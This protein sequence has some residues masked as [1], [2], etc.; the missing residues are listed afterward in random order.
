MSVALSASSVVFRVGGDSPAKVRLGSVSIQ[1]VPTKPSLIN[2]TTIT[3]FPNATFLRITPHSDGGSPI[4]RYKATFGA[5]ELNSFTMGTATFE[6]ST[7][8]VAGF[9]GNYI[10][11]TSSVQ[12]RNRIG[13]SVPSDTF[14]PA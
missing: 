4:D 12:A 6:G 13:L 8:V 7:V 9:F 1:D 11:Q 14:V 3:T 5:T 10:G 2:V